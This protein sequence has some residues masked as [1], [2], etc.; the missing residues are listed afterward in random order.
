MANQDGASMENRIVVITGGSRGLG[1]NTALN[2][3][4]RGVD[5]ILTFRVNQTEAESLIREIKKLGR[6]A[7]AFHLEVDLGPMITAFLSDENRW[8]NGQRIEV[9]GGMNL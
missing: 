1:R 8:V 4:R 6:K 2:L 5:V 3:A 7:A 9:S